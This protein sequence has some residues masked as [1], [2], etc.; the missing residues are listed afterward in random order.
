MARLFWMVAAVLLV[1]VLWSHADRQTGFD[2]ERIHKE[3]GWVDFT[4]CERDRLRD[5]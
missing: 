4:E 1:A 5:P 3:T 2:C